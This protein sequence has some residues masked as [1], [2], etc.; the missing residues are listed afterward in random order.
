MLWISLTPIVLAALAL[1][2]EVTIPDTWGIC[3]RNLVSREG[4]TTALL[5]STSHV[6]EFRGRV[7]DRL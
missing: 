4:S 7:M 6:V 3:I 5:M 1:V 2:K